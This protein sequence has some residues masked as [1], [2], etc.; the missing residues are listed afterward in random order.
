MTTGGD[1]DAIVTQVDIR[2]SLQVRTER[3]LI[4][5]EA[6]YTRADYLEN[7]DSNDGV[8]ARL[9]ATSRIK[10]NLTLRT[11]ISFDSSVLG[12][13]GPV[14]ARDGGGQIGLPGT[15]GLPADQVPLEIDEIPDGDIEL[16]GLR[17]RRNSLLVEASAELR[18]GPRSLWTL[19]ASAARAD[20]PRSGA[21]ANYRSIGTTVEHRRD[22]SQT[23]SAGGR[24]DLL[25]VKYRGGPTSNVYTAQGFVSLQLA[26]RWTLEASAGVSVLDSVTRQALF[27]GRATMCNSGPG[28]RFCFLASRAPAVSGFSGVRGQTSLGGTFDYP[29]DAHSSLSAAVTYVWTER[30]PASIIDGRRFL[31]ATTTYRRDLGGQVSLYAAIDYRRLESE[32]IIGRSDFAAR[33]GAS[34]RLGGRR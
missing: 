9:N 17:Q 12:V 2:P 26:E 20:Y 30:N 5:L 31:T 15:G 7:F 24:A 16:L 18:T 28:A 33:I 32:G 22:L 13:N 6:F 3:D 27:S 1:I 23:L 4:Y 8:G 11:T 34:V 25:V 14:L 10:P 19:S 21:A 29:I